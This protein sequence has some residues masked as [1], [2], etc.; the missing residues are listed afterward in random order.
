LA[1]Q[2]SRRRK[3]DYTKQLEEKVESLEAQ[4][5]QLNR[6]IDNLKIKLNLKL[7]GE[8]REFKEAEDTNVMFREDMLKT[9]EKQEDDQQK[10][11]EFFKL[12]KHYH[13]LQGPVGADRIKVIK[14]ATR[15]I[16][17]N[18]IPDGLRYGL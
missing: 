10:N 1:A 9:V 6:K 5:Q 17:E 2:L 16:I 7:I 15:F 13:T 11:Q 12:L 3:K 18:L 4:I 14:K 8:E